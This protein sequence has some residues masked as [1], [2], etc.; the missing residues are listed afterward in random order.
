MS[1]ARRK[2]QLGGQTVSEVKVMGNLSRFEVGNGDCR[3]L[4]RC[5]PLGTYSVFE[6]F[7]L[8]LARFNDFLHG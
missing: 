8:Q 7:V 5:L 6:S 1:L 2:F 4:F 3:H